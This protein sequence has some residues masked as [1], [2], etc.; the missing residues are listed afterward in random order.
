MNTMNQPARPRLLIISQVYVP[1]T[2]AVGQYMADVATEMA[3]RGWD[4]VVYTSARGYDDPSVRF[5]ARETSGGVLWPLTA[6]ENEPPMRPSQRSKR[7]GAAIFCKLLKKCS[8]KV[9]RPT[10]EVGA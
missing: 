1:D 10:P 6:S 5:P 3:A 7:R 8:F 4:V 9:G 2:A